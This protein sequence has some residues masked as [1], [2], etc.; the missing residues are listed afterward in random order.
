MATTVASRIRLTW[1]DYGAFPEDGQRHEIIDGEHYVAASPFLNHQSILANL[2]FQL[3]SQINE[4]RRGSVFPAPTAVQLSPHDIVEPDLLVVLSEHASYLTQ[5]KVD[6]PPDLV[7]EILSPSSR[8]KD[9]DLKL[10]LYR[11]A[12]VGEYWI[13]DPQSRQVE[14]YRRE[15][16]LLVAAGTFS[17]RIAF[18]AVPGV[19][20]DLT[21]VWDEA[22]A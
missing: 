9:R 5:P 21:R 13:V 22:D 1:D 3:Y 2:R 19:V 8:R 15:G 20:V 12:G 7:V 14:Q 17:D 18:G 10:R 4:H 11:R 16:D 6:G